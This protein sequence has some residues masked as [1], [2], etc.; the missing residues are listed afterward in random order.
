M[1]TETNQEELAQRLFQQVRRLEI[2]TRRI[3]NT[4][5]AGDYQ[6]AFKGNGLAF[7]EVR[8]YQAGDDI[9]SID[10]NVSARMGELYIKMFKEEREQNLF[11]LFDISDSEEFGV[12]YYT[13]KNIGAEIAALFAFSAL[14]NQDKFG[15]ATF[16]DTLEQ[17]YK[18]KRGRTYILKIIRNILK[19]HKA[20]SKT[21]IALAINFLLLTLRQKCILVVISDFIDSQY[22]QALVQLNR[23][24]EVILIRLYHPLELDYAERAII[25]VEELES[26]H[27]RWVNVAGHRYNHSMQNYFADLDEQLTKLKNKH[28]IDYASVNVTENY[29]PVLE[30]LLIHRKVRKR[31]RS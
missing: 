13:K 8:P 28:G 19:D 27:I 11:V 25:P 30:K 22:E 23:K 15:L 12:S 20:S 31:K 9:R 17:F 1:R 4:S 24:H 10:W 7:E 14:K 29:L 5:L 3:V 21:N 16:T 18:P 2:K 6:A 26:G